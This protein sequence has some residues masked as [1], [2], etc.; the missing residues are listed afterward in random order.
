MKHQTL[1][2]ILA[3]LA[4]ALC[5][6]ADQ[7]PTSRMYL[8]DPGNDALVRIDGNS[9]TAAPLQS[10]AEFAIAVD[11]VVRT[12]AWTITP[13]ARYGLDL[14]FTGRTDEGVDE[15]LWDATTDG[16]FIY[17]VDQFTHDVV[18]YRKNWTGK[19]VLFPA[20][21]DS[22]FITYDPSNHSLWIAGAS[23][24]VEN[25]SMQG[26]LL[27]RFDT[28]LDGVQPLALDYADDTLWC[29]S[30]DEPGVFLQFNKRGGL[31]QT[32]DYGFDDFAAG[33]EF[34]L[35]AVAAI[36][37]VRVRRGDAIND[38]R[39]NL[40]ESDNQRIRIR[41]EDAGNGLDWAVCDLRF[42]AKRRELEAVDMDLVIEGH[43]DAP[44]GTC[45]VYAKNWRSGEFDLIE[46]YQMSDRDA[47]SVIIHLNPRRYLSNRNNIL[48]RLCMITQDARGPQWK[49][50]LDL[51]EMRVR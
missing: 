30:G 4:P 43:L 3:A 28:G 16:R 37:S 10:G 31:L 46:S 36:K 27:S 14:A 29:G 47:R 26:D 17:S 1:P 18:R 12:M 45:K 42:K 7:G 33:A 35:G 8:T 48:I 44:G 24:L 20:P 11:G 50:F 51:A 9:V 34:D 19:V 21:A 23:G 40:E 13:G 22:P 41:S 32:C 38:D 5:G 49:A 39:E 6:S 15:F 2:I 25:Y